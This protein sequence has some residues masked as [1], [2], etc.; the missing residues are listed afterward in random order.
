MGRKSGICVGKDF[1]LRLIWFHVIYEK[2]KGDLGAIA[3]ASS[4]PAEQDR[5]KE[6]QDSRCPR[7]QDG[8]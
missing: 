3:R 4:D 8:C 5:A 1:F 7:R 2:E 6:I